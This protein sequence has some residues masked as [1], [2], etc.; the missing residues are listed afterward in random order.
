M[1]SYYMYLTIHSSAGI[2][3]KEIL[4]VL[5]E[6]FPDKDFFI[7]EEKFLSVR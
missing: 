3:I 1:N 6:A 2:D 5:K 7:G 4:K